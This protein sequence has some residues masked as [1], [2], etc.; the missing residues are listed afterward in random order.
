MKRRPGGGR[1]FRAATCRPPVAS[2]GYRV[3][4]KESK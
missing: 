1:R 3:D 2:I 4:T